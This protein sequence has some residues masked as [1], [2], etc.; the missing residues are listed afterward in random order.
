MILNAK[1]SFVLLHVRTLHAS[2]SVKL[3]RHTE[4]QSAHA[5][6]SLTCA[7]LKNGADWINFTQ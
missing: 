5:H 3:Q 6:Y 1:G 2:G 4:W 7:C